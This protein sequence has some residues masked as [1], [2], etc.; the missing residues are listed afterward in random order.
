MIFSRKLASIMR[1]AVGALCMQALSA[2]AFAQ[3][4]DLPIPAAA[5]DTYPPGVSVVQTAQGPV[6]ADERGLTL[7]GMDM[8]TLIYLS[9]NPAMY[10]QGACAEEWEPLLAPPGST[11]N[12]AYPLTSGAAASGLAGR[13]VPEDFIKPAEAPDWTIVEGP[14]GAQ[15][16][17]KG[18]HVVYTR[19][20]DAPGS[21]QH[22]GSDD[23]IWNTLKFVPPVPDFDAPPDVAATFVDGDYVLANRDGGLLFTGKCKEACGTWKPM[24][25]GL[26]DRGFGGWAVDRGGDRPQWMYRGA[27]VFVSD[28]SGTS[29][30]PKDGAVLQVR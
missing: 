24:P 26:A 16:V 14:A 10:C 13:T 20:G 17:Y 4:V 19:R 15:W 25:A 11:P 8:R 1:L 9:P 18:W 6:Y 5:T 23:F 22:D 7:Y 30:V 28:G 29:S 27:P 12:I 21:T 2:T 3:P